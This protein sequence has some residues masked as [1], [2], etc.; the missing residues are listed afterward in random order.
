MM[1]YNNFYRYDLAYEKAVLGTLLLQRDAIHQVR[2]ILGVDCLDDQW[3]QN[4]YKAILAMSSR[5]ER[6]DKITVCSELKKTSVEFQPFDIVDLTNT[7]TF[8]LTQ[9]AL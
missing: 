2:E 9:Y 5:G 7:Q 4:V 8:D 1:A 6:A 3:H